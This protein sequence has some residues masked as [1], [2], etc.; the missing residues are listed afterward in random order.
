[1]RWWRFEYRF[2]GKEKL[3]DYGIPPG[4]SLNVAC[5]HDDAA[6]RQLTDP[7]DLSAPRRMRRRAAP[8]AI[9][10]LNP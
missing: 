9:T 6:H 7:V 1:M 3:L 8:R 2:A 4:L 5:E 10:A